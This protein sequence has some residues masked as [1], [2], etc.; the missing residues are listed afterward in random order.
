MNYN[1]ETT[2]LTEYACPQCHATEIVRKQSY[3]STA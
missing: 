2:K 3:H 1:D